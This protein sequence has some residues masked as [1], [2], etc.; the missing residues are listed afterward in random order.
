MS[1]KREST[2]R[3]CATGTA[4]LQPYVKKTAAAGTRLL[5]STDVTVKFEVAGVPKEAA[6]GMQET[7]KAAVAGGGTLQTNLAAEVAGANISSLDGVSVDATASATAVDANW[8]QTMDSVETN[9]EFSVAIAAAAVGAV[10][11]LCVAVVVFKKKK[12]APQNET[13][14]HFLFRM[15]KQ[16]AR[17]ETSN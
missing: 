15:R 4:R 8:E 1:N 3:T 12:E 17:F 11:A 14:A 5:L 13:K 9:T 2:S 7:L 16:R 6:T 10:V